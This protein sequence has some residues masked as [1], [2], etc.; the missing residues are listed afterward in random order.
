MARREE[1]PFLERWMEDIFLALHRTNKIASKKLLKGRD[2]ASQIALRSCSGDGRLF[3]SRLIGACTSLHKF[4]F[5]AEMPSSDSRS[6]LFLFGCTKLLPL[7]SQGV[8][9]PSKIFPAFFCFQ[10]FREADVY[11]GYL[12][13]I[14]HPSVAGSNFPRSSTF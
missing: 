9:L 5:L 8:P 2:A 7:V 10:L 1:F 3:S 11:G 6:S 4:P 14:H 13:L 12:G